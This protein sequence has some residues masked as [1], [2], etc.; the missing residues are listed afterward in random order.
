MLVRPLQLFR[1]RSWFMCLF[2]AILS[3]CRY[4]PFHV[5]CSFLVVDS[6]PLPLMLDSFSYV[7]RI[8]PGFVTRCD[9]SMNV[10]VDTLTVGIVKA[11]SA[12]A[13]GYNDISRGTR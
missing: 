7:L 6:L 11:S 2:T 9:R 10:L 8:C 4:A 3:Y 1:T 5:C 13:L 12:S